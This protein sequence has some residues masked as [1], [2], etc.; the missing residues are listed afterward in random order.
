[1]AVSNRDDRRSGDHKKGSFKKK[2][3]PKT[4][5]KGKQVSPEVAKTRAAGLKSKWKRDNA[6]FMAALALERGESLSGAGA[7]M[8]LLATC[9]LIQEADLPF[10]DDAES[11]HKLN[12]CFD[13]AAELFHS[14]RPTIKWPLL[15]GA[16]GRGL[17]AGQDNSPGDLRLES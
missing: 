10:G 13:R 3:G 7:R 14:T 16:A 11:Q 2:S 1:M 9:H 15:E 4:T 12:A 5:S 17:E 8:V 6:K